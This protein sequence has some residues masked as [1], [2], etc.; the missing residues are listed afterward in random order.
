MAS[1][2]QQLRTTWLPYAVAALGSFPVHPG[3]WPRPQVLQ[4]LYAQTRSLVRNEGLRA[5]LSIAIVPALLVAPA[6]RV[7]SSPSTQNPTSQAVSQTTVN[8]AAAFALKGI[9]I[10]NDQS[11][12]ANQPYQAVENANDLAYL[13]G[14]V[15]RVRIALAYGMDANDV[16]NLKRLAVEA[17]K[18]GFYVQFGISAGSD[19]DVSTY[20][21]RWIS[22]DIVETATWAQ[23][24]H[25]DEFS[26]GNEEDWYCEVLGAFT[27]KTPTEIRNDVKAKVAEVRKVY[28][29]SIVY[30]DSQGTLDDWIKEGIGGLDRIY[31]NVYDT[32]PNFQGIINKIVANF[33]TDHAGL[34]EWAALHG[35]NEMV[36]DGMSPQQYSQEIMNRDAVVKKSGLPAYLFT[37]RMD[38]NGGGW[39]FV[40]G[41]GT[42]RP[43]LN[44][45][46]AS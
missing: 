34:A 41:D 22:T 17:K 31:F 40:L 23:L 1:R 26:I 7:F 12:T 38:Q 14:K 28:S 32:F 6:T 16:N 42:R 21:D 9:N 44:E 35:Y 30:A 24:H 15:S 39:G 3:Q 10:G 45:F 46:L 11:S 25:I 18:Q 27:A 29:G 43:G 13:K 2:A 19:P 4:R 33:G 36:Q 5:V 37:L 8:P 20:Y